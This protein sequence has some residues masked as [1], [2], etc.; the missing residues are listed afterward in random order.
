M[1]LTVALIRI[2]T[3][4]KGSVSARRAQDEHERVCFWQPRC[5]E[6]RSCQITNAYWL[7]GDYG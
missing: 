4:L 3:I 5:L 7:L 2:S 1:T 6:T